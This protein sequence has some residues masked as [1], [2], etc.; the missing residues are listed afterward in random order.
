MANYL[1]KYFFAGYLAFSSGSYEANANF[2]PMEQKL[3]YIH[4]ARTVVG[5]N[6]MFWAKKRQGYTCD[7]NKAG[8]YSEEEAYSQHRCR[9]TDIPLLVSEVDKLAK[10]YFDI[11][12][13][14][15]I[16]NGTK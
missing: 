6:S 4:V 16:E 10:S 1:L 3:Y 2:K 9:A 5:N 8:K 11:Q 7:L 15:R 12:D 13:I 14:D